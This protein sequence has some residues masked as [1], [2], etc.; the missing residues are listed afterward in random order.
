MSKIS[1]SLQIVWFKRDLRLRDHRPLLE[2]AKAGPVLPLYCIEPSLLR[3]PDTGSRHLRF[4][5]QSLH[6]LK[7][8]LQALGCPLVVMQGEVVPLLESLRKAHGPFRLWSHEETG[9]A[10]TF[11]RDRAVKKWANTHRL[12]WTELPQNGVVRGLTDRD[13]WSRHWNRRMKGDPLLA[14][15]RLE[16]WPDPPRGLPDLQIRQT[17]APKEA[18]TP[19]SRGGESAGWESLESFFRERGSGYRKKMSSPVTAYDACSR[20]SAHLAWGNLSIHQVV[21]R[22]REVLRA[23]DDEAPPYAIQKTDLRSFLSRCHWHCHFMQKLEREPAIERHCFNR[24]CEDLRPRPPEPERL[25]AWIEGQTGY[26]FIDACRRALRATGWINFRMRAML[27]SF[28]AYHLWIDWRD[29]AHPLAR[30]FIDYEP[31]IHYSQIQMQSGTTGINT[32]RIYSPVKQG[33]DQ[34]PKGTFIRKWVPELAALPEEW[35]QEPWTAPAAILQKAGIRLGK[36][37]PRPIVDHAEAVRHARS[38]FT[39]LR[40]SDFFWTEARRVQEIHGS[41]NS[42]ENR[43]RPQRPPS[44]DQQG[45]LP[46]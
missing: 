13:H 10:L 9:N 15:D 42:R 8:G 34:D 11:S 5:Y 37:Y 28:V 22:A 46:L 39:T 20:V 12:N 23:F 36:T 33:K 45:Q 14:P 32:L 1:P 44:R 16:P 18:S 17:L 35:I 26:P 7:D 24:A 21:H 43:G 6:E 19:C 41:R 3:A 31:G 2:A 29:F 40:K 30:D 25:E 38:R 27:V 4:I